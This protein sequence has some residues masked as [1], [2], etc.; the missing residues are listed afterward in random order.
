MKLWY[1]RIPASKL[2]FIQKF[3]GVE[4]KLGWGRKEYIETWER[5]T[6]AVLTHFGNRVLLLPVEFSDS[7]KLRFLSSF[8]ACA[9]KDWTYARSHTSQRSHSSNSL[10]SLSAKCKRSPKKCGF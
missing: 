9:P 7:E 10:Q 6:R 4:N 8:M 1:G 5:H 3:F 2:H